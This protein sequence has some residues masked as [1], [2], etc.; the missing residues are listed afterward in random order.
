ML[1]SAAVDEIISD[2]SSFSLAIKIHPTGRSKN[3][4]KP[5]RFQSDKS[6]KNTAPL[7]RLFDDIATLLIVFF[8]GFRLRVTKRIGVAAPRF[9]LSVLFDV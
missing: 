9:F 8:S 4:R 3:R 1:A 7:Q 2:V 5:H 6:T